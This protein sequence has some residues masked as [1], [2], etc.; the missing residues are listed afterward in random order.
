[1]ATYGTTAG[2]EAYVRHMSFDAANNPT[3]DQVDQWLAERSA[4]LTGW[5]ASSGYA[6]PVVQSDAKAVL[7]RY[8]NIGA[9]GDAELA[10]RSA[11]YAATDENKRENK[12]LSEFMRAEAGSPAARS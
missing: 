12:F 1:M 4:Q 7:D 9:A 5:L 6:V 11:G 10:Q 2:V 8:A 3:T